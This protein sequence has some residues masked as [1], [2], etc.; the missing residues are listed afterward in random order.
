MDEVRDWWMF[1][2]YMLTLV[3][4][5]Y[6]NPLTTGYF[7]M[8]ISFCNTTPHNCNISV[9][10]WYTIMII[11]S[12]L[13]ILMSWCFSTRASVVTVLSTHPCIYSCLWFKKHKNIFVF[14]MIYQGSDGTGNSNPSTVGNNFVHSRFSTLKTFYGASHQQALAD[15]KIRQNDYHI[16]SSIVNYFYV[17]T[18]W[19]TF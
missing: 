19:R 4:W 9:W 2:C 16:F 15:Y 5:I 3:S 1:C 6:P 14:S 18:A 8:H 12:A 17:F 7:L 11:Q 10:N 13:W